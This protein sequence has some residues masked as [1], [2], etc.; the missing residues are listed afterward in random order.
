KGALPYAFIPKHRQ[1]L[2]PE[3]RRKR[4]TLFRGIKGAFLR[5][6]CSLVLKIL[7]VFG[8]EQRIYQIFRM[9]SDLY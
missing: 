8:M 2:E 5:R 4:P 7:A 6:H 3:M 9:R 1:A